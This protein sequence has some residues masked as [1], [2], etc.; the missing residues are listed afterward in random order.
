M[1]IV[2][3]SAVTAAG[4]ASQS[5]TVAAASNGAV[6]FRVKANAA[7]SV[8]FSVTFSEERPM[9]SKTGGPL[10]EDREERRLWVAPKGVPVESRVD[11]TLA[12][13]KPFAFEVDRAKDDAHVEA[14][15][16]I[17]FPSAVPM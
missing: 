13:G 14:D 1:S 4:S 12:D 3:P 2:G 8:P 6:K 9:G 10:R 11:A 15:L 16:S 5:I 17:A 7:G